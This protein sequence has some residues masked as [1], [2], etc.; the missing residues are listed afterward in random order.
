MNRRWFQPRAP[1]DATLGPPAQ[2]KQP[3]EVREAPSLP[4]LQ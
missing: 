4:I 2:G 3:V 1:T